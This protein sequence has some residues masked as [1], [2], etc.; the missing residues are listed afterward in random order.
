[1]LSDQGVPN[2]DVSRVA[3]VL[4]VQTWKGV[5]DFKT[6]QNITCATQGVIY[7]AICPCKKIYIGLTS[8]QL[9]RRTRQHV[10]GIIAAREIENMEEL[11]T[12]PQHFKECH[13]SDPT[14]LKV[15]GIDRVYSS[16][17]GS[18][19]NQVLAQKEMRWTVLL[20]TMHPF[21]LTE[22]LNY[23]AFL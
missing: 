10:L 1:M 11:R 15:K 9:R 7:M 8:R 16:I 17:R 23:S 13:N 4:V 18:D 20:N 21:G 12:L 22:T 2:G 3:N 5:M 6:V 14:G 19:L